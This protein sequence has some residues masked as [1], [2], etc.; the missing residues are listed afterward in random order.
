MKV[1]RFILID[2]FPE[3][4][5]C[6]VR[7]SGPIQ[8]ATRGLSAEQCSDRP[9]PAT[10]YVLEL[11]GLPVNVT[12]AIGSLENPEA[13]AT[14]GFLLPA[15][16]YIADHLAS[17]AF[18]PDPFPVEDWKAGR[19]LEAIGCADEVSHWEKLACDAKQARIVE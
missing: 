8:N 6:S 13:D 15:A 12:K 1:G 7:G 4:G 14:A 9:S 3:E 11:W 17:R 18:P 5:Q 16:L 19:Y 10:G 2:N